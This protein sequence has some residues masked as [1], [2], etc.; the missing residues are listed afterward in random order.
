MKVFVVVVDISYEYDTQIITKVF[1][2]RA[3]AMKFMN[4]K[5]EQE[6]NEVD[7]DTIER[8]DR[9]CSAYNEGWFAE[10]HCEISIEEQEVEE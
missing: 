1:K 7:Y 8:N 5:F 3:K 4:E 9:V 6:I 2:D 10:T